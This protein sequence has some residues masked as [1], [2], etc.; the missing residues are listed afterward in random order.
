MREKFF[1]IASIEGTVSAVATNDIIVAVNG[2]GYRVFVSLGTTQFTVG[3]TTF[4]Y[5][6]LAVRENALDLYGFKTQQ[7]RELFDLL[8]G[9]PKIGPKTALQIL[10]QAGVKLIYESV[11][12]GD[13][14]HLSKMSGMGKK[15]AE[16]VVMGLKDSL[17]D[18]ADDG[19]Y[20]NQNGQH[21]DLID[22]L[23]ALG[24]S[25]KD[26]RDVLQNIDDET[27]DTETLLKEALKTLSS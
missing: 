9:L 22:A 24:Y 5:T 18:F 15:T 3:E 16:K 17:A 11:Q 25:G 14:A 6:H 12:R 1:M 21:G 26:S 10:S 23:V 4:L 19:S 20:T 27:K 8:L 2:I 7:E 13:A